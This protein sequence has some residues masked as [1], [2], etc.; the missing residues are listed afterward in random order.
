MFKFFIFIFFPFLIYFVTS[1]ERKEHKP[2]S[3]KSPPTHHFYHD[4]SSSNFI[5]LCYQITYAESLTLKVRDV[6]MSYM[7]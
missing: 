5:W 7:S 4:M 3:I 1:H 6:N 2:P